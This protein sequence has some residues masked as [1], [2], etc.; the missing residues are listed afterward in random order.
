MPRRSACE[1]LAQAVHVRAYDLPHCRPP[2]QPADPVVQIGH[3]IGLG[4]DVSLQQRLECVRRGHLYHVK[5]SELRAS[6]TSGAREP[7]SIRLEHARIRASMNSCS[8]RRAAR[9]GVSLHRHLAKTTPLLTMS[10]FPGLRPELRRMASRMRSTLDAIMI[11]ST[12][13]DLRRA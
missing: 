6:G 2:D 10:A 4:K 9:G 12:W 8:C 5:G 3:T 7:P 13:E 1:D 11:P